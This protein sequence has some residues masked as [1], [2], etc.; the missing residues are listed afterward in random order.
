MHKRS[1]AERVARAWWRKVYRLVRIHRRE[2]AKAMNDALLFGTGLMLTRRDGES[3]H[4]P[5]ESAR[6]QALINDSLPLHP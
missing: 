5:I 2:N 4:I 1:H 3:E 6:A